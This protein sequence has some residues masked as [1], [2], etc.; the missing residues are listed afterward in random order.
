M[1][2]FRDSPFSS[3]CFEADSFIFYSTLRQG[4]AS[5]FFTAI[6][7][8]QLTKSFK[9]CKVIHVHMDLHVHHLSRA[10]PLM[11]HLTTRI[12]PISQEYCHSQ[13]WYPTLCINNT[14]LV[15]LS[16]ILFTIYI[17]SVLL[18]SVTW[19]AI[20]LSLQSLICFSSLK[21]PSACSKI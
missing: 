6:L 14:M 9:P 4:F 7:C 13:T 17:A 5:I 21:S 3:H 12:F 16:Y 1:A 15:L 20:A 18:V 8:W 2:C 10:R 19:P 11:M